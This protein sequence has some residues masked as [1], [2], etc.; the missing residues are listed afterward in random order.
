[1]ADIEEMSCFT[2]DFTGCKTIMELYAVIRKEF[3]LPDG[4][5][6]DLDALGDALKRMIYMPAEITV[7][8]RFD[9][10]DLYEYIQRIIEVIREAEEE[11]S[12]RMVK[13]G[14]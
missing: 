3:E 1:M 8:Y 9:D 13:P 11:Y 4:F 5:G 7:K 10:L 2:L 12:K 6:N 14:E